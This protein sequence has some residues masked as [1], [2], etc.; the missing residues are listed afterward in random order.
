MNYLSNAF[1]LNMFRNMDDVQF[2]RIK[3]I[4]PKDIPSKE[5]ISVVGH[6]DM[7]T[8]LSDMLGFE[9][10]YNRAS[11]SLND[12][13]IIYVAQYVGP[14]L[15]EGATILPENAEIKFFEIKLPHN[16][17]KTCYGLDCGLCHLKAFGF[18]G[19]GKPWFT[20]A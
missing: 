4:T 9:V 18:A 14:R 16:P 2:L 11:L 1:S 8:I 12:G 3:S 15:P 17:C 20:G 7:A 5:V 6:K 13:D 10:A 19:N